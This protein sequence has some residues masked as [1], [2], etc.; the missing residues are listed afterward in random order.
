PLVTAASG[1]RSSSGKPERTRAAAPPGRV[2]LRGW[3]T[4][5][6]GSLGLILLLDPIIAGLP[7]GDNGRSRLAVSWQAALRT[8][9]EPDSRAEILCFGDSLIKLGILPRVLEARVGLS[10]YNLSVLGGQPPTSDYLLRRILE[11]GHVPRA[12]IVDFSPL[13][14]GLDPRVNLGWWA[15]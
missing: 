14:L 9:T 6:I 4:G 13:M 12:L 10:A 3:P 5:L 1:R 11:R 2:R 15:G 7:T 8:A